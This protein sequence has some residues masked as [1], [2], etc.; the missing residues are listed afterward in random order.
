MVDLFF[1]CKSLCMAYENG[2]SP[3]KVRG[4][5]KEESFSL[6]IIFN[7]SHQPLIVHFYFVQVFLSCPLAAQKDQRTRHA[8]SPVGLFFVQE[9]LCNILQ[10]KSPCHLNLS[11]DFW[12]MRT[13]LS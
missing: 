6:A 13:F 8:E 3:A 12:V 11:V 2:G 4:M 7:G 1:V 5:Y 10:S 9:L